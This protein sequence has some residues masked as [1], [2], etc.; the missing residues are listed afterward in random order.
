MLDITLITLKSLKYISY[1]QTIHN[2]IYALRKTKSRGKKKL[3]SVFRSDGFRGHY[4]LIRTLFSLLTPSAVLTSSRRI[5]AQKIISLPLV[6]LWKIYTQN[7]TW[8][9]LL[10]YKYTPY[11]FFEY[12]IFF[13]DEMISRIENTNCTE[14]NPQ[15]RCKNNLQNVK[16]Q[17]LSYSVNGWDKRLKRKLKPKNR[18]IW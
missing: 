9:R 7:I 11:L 10:E 1:R 5:E 18:S 16:W 3:C 17:M 6:T 12:I 14:K 13:R 15:K 8:V 2:L 4:S